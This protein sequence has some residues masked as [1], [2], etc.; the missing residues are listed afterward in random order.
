MAT[1]AAEL[2]RFH[3]GDGTVGKLCADQDVH[4][5]DHNKE[6]R[7]ASKS[8][9]AIEI[10]LNEPFFYMAFAEIDSDCNQSQPRKEHDWKNEKNDDADVRITCVTTDLERKDE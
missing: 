6:P 3:I 7:D 10:R 5:R 9:F 2:W 8:G 1:G 4:D